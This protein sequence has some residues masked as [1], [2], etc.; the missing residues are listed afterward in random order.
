MYWRYGGT[1]K[2]R[3]AR[4]NGRLIRVASSRVISRS[5]VRVFV[6][7]RRDVS[8]LLF[9][10]MASLPERDAIRS[11]ISLPRTRPGNTCDAACFDVSAETSLA[12]RYVID[13]RR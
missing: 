1:T 9:R 13:V 7:S 4:A 8:V 11:T 6:T 5:H 12:G 3:F 10:E 2:I